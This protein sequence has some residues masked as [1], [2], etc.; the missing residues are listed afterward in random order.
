MIFLGNNYSGYWIPETLLNRKGTIYGIGLGP[1][2]SFE[3]ELVKLGYSF[4]GFEPEKTSYIKSKKQFSN[5]ES[6]LF[7][8][9]ISTLNDNFISR[10]S[11]FSIAKTYD[12]LPVNEQVFRIKS[13]WDVCRD[14]KLEN[15]NKPR[16]LKMNIE[17]AEKEILKKFIVNPLDFQLITFQAEF[18]FHLRFYQIIERL[19]EF[20]E[21]WKILKGF[22][23]LG[24]RI[25]HIHKNQ[26]T[27]TKL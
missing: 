22:E 13:L 1:D 14:L 6:N 20:V 19:K 24:W 4:W 7:N 25:V 5:T 15:S 10:G 27:I 17:G 12:H 18:V 11:N 23:K 2:S 9:G 26:I 21:L 16:V 8:Y 3:H